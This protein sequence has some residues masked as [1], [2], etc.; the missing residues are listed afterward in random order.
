MATALL[1]ARHVSDGIL[2]DVGS[3]TTDITP[4]EGGRVM[5]EGR[6]DPERLLAGELLYTGAVRTNV[7]AIVAE[8]P[9]GGRPCPVAAELFA[10]AGDVH[11]L[12]G[13]LDPTEYTSPTPDG[14]P[15][16][17]DF[18]AER[19]A[20][21][22]CADVEMLPHGAIVQIAQTVADAQVR[23][24]AAALKRVAARLPRPRDVIVTGLGAFL[25]VSAA[26]AC[27]LPARDLSDVL[28]V[29]VG[30]AAPAVAIA[31]LLGVEH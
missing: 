13:S 21:V 9:L 26:K 12:L 3:T 20:R 29:E 24:I 14:R 15:A 25:G 10:V 27:G 4:I 17:P 19:L 18:A 1:V 23:Q 16:T 22:V 8:V 6:T 30:L 5:A 2:I 7:A 28:G 11:V 31:W